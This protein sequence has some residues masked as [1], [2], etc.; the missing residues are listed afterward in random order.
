LLLRAGELRTL[1][2][3]SP[4]IFSFILSVVVQQDK[5]ERHCRDIPG[6]SAVPQGGDVILGL[7]QVLASVRAF[8]CPEMIRQPE[9]AFPLIKRYAANITELDCALHQRPCDAADKVLARCIRLESLT[10]TRHYAPSAWLQLSQ[11]HTLR[12]VDLS[13][14]SIAAI[15]AALPRLHTLDAVTTPA[16]V[17]AAALAGFSDDLLPRLHVFQYLGRWPQNLSSEDAASSLCQLQLPQLR[18]LSLRSFRSHPP[19]WTW[20]MGAR[21]LEL[22]TDAVM[23]EHWLPP[24]LAASGAGAAAACRGEALGPLASV[25]TLHI[26]VQPPAVFTATNVA[27]LLHAAPQLETLV[28]FAL[29]VDADESWLVDPA[30]DG[31]VHLKLKRVRLFGIPLTAP[32]SSDR[33]TSLRQRHFPRLRRAAID[34]CEYFVTPLDAL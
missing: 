21:P 13:V 22:W 30:F 33:L 11:L 27:R 9:A 17:T 12:G 3:T 6:V 28:V 26:A 8:A 18:T 34:G 20:F 25:R 10:N 32:L 15:A 14:V 23:I 19:P 4:A 2:V 1:R 31:L 24:T 7:S 16:G 5:Q 29:G